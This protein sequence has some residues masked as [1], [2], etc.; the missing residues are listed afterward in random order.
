MSPSYWATC[1]NDSLVGKQSK[2]RKKRSQYFEKFFFA[3]IKKNPNYIKIK[4]NYDGKKIQIIAQ[5]VNALLENSPKFQRKSQ[6]DKEK[7]VNYLT[8]TQNYKEKVKI[9]EQTSAI[10]IIMSSV[11]M[12]TKSPEIL[13]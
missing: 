1:P 10:D 5:K 11:N 4:P 7:K 9:I 6:N 13:K 2:S 12:E 3:A 8:I